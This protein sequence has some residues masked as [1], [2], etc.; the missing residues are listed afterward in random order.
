MKVNT[1]VGLDLGASSIRAVQITR[2]LKGDVGIDKIAEEPLPIGAIHE[3]EVVDYDAVTSALQSLW[4]SARFTTKFV[5]IG[6]G[7]SSTR[8]ITGEENHVNDSDF[9]KLL[10]YLPT[11]ESLA[12]ASE[13]Y[14]MDWHTLGEYFAKEI[15]KE[16]D[17]ERTIKKKFILVGAGTKDVVDS[18]VRVALKAGLKPIS[19]D[20]NALAMIRSWD[21]H[22]IPSAYQDVDVSIDLGSDTLTVALHKL[23][24][25][26]FVRAQRGHVGKSVTEAISKELGISMAL[27]ERRK[28]EHMNMVEPPKLAE[29]VF[30]EGSRIPQ[31]ADSLDELQ[32]NIDR[33]HRIE[34]IILAAVQ[35]A[36]SSVKDT[37]SHFQSMS[38]GDDLYTLSS[39]HLSGLFALTPT[40]KDR[41]AA[42]LDVQVVDA[43]PF[44]ANM[45]NRKVSK[46]PDGVQQNELAF[47][48]AYGLAIGEGSTHA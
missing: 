9:A 22:K 48:V 18:R 41:L 17:E 3:G 45:S 11:A 8:T 36:I 35:A 43:E 1:V 27:A 44:T 19:V 26:L 24:Q 31:S 25:P 5:R 20:L 29:P 2:G 13:S 6:V 7:D 21:E 37:I 30:G 14:Y 33:Y 4:K 34:P 28:I 16:T 46:L 12:D 39:I 23:G 40:L 42:E 47:A 32:R 38:A 15:D 10:P